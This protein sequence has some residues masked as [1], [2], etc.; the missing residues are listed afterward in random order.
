MALTKAAIKKLVAS[1]TRVIRAEYPKATDFKFDTDGDDGL[2]FNYGKKT[3]VSTRILYTALGEIQDFPSC[4]GYLVLTNFE[5]NPSVIAQA[6]F[7]LALHGSNWNPRAAALFAT[8]ANQPGVD[9]MLLANGFGLIHTGTNPGTGNVLRA[10]IYKIT[11]TR[12]RRRP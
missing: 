1:A 10:Y 9:K 4:C 11:T 7:T 2:S 8:T 6:A 5:T 12:S 3:H